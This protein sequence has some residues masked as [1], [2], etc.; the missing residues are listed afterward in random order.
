MVDAALRGIADEGD[1]TIYKFQAG[2][3]EI[4][5]IPDGYDSLSVKNARREKSGS[6]EPCAAT[7][8]GYQIHPFDIGGALPIR[9]CR[10]RVTSEIIGF[11]YGNRSD[12]RHRERADCRYLLYNF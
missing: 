2:D 10:R 11:A 7:N 8:T 9:E 3:P 12:P 6:R 5:E 1:F 4:R